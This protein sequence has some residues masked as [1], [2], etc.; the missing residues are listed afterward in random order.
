MV[1]NKEVEF[2]S[3]EEHFWNKVKRAHEERL[4]VLEQQLKLTPFDIIHTKEIIKNAKIRLK[5]FKKTAC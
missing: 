3:N 2:V 4:F 5:K 1:S